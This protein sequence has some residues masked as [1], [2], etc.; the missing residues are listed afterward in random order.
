MK[1]RFFSL[2]FVAI[3]MMLV[4]CGG[5]NKNT[6]GN[7]NNG[8][9]T[10]S[11][12]AYANVTNNVLIPGTQFEKVDFSKYDEIVVDED[13][14]NQKYLVNKD[15]DGTLWVGLSIGDELRIP[16]IYNNVFGLG[17]APNYV[18][19]RKKAGKSG[20]KWGVCSVT[21]GKEVIPCEYDG[22]KSDFDVDGGLFYT[23]F[24][25]KQ[26]NFYLNGI[27]A[28]G[29]EDPKEIEP[30]EKGGK[31]GVLVD[32]KVRVEAK[33]DGLYPVPYRPRHFVFKL[34]SNY[35]LIHHTGAVI[36]PGIY[37]NFETSISGVYVKGVVFFY[38]QAGKAV[39]LDTNGDPA[40]AKQVTQ[41][42]IEKMVKED[43]DKL[44][45]N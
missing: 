18:L 13:D 27:C 33:Y 42:D 26:K 4:A 41:E 29:I 22:I 45:G 7:E 9:N 34:G 3:A 6:A 2:V 35:G 5:G 1:I 25:G 43:Y 21:T 44:Y 28:D 40:P 10:S 19:V 39:P 30:F 24:G 15:P 17:K 23:N 32:G 8:D 37:K 31:W 38:D 12:D 16:A 20:E 36:V 11:N 14:K